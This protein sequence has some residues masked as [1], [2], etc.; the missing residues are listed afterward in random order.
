MRLHICKD[1]QL[2]LSYIHMIFH[3]ISKST[4]KYCIR[5]FQLI[6][7]NK[8]NTVHCLPLLLRSNKKTDTLSAKDIEQDVVM[9]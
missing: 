9:K 6:I 7:S 2:W 5:L 3:L 4:Q 1:C 8:N